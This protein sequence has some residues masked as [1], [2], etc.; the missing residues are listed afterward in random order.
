MFPDCWK[1]SNVCPISKSGNRS[2]ISNYRPVCLL[3][4]SEKVFERTGFKHIHDHFQDN[5]ILTPLQ[6]GFIPGDPTVNQLTYLYDSFSQ[7]LG[8]GKEVRVVFC[9]ISRAFDFVWHEGLIK[10]LEA[11]GITG[12]LLTWFCS[13]LSDRRQRVV[14]PCVESACNFIRAGVPQGSIL[15]PLLFLRFINDIVTDIGSNI[16]AYLAY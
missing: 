12:N 2:S 16:R 13:Y 3:C 15:G 7:A 9:D 1:I 6:S 14:L 8:F 11:A 4:T 10:K 5:T